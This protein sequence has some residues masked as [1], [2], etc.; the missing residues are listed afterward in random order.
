MAIPGREQFRQ[1]A[2]RYVELPGAR[3]L[4]ALRLTPNAVTLLGFA[5]CAVASFLVGS[6]WLLA[7]GI[8]FLAGS[9]LDLMD[10]ALARLTGTVRPFGA[11]AGLGIRP[12]WRSGDVPGTG[13]IRPEGRLQR[14]LPAVLH[15]GRVSGVD[16]LAGSELS[17]GP[18]RRV[19]S[20][21]PGRHHDQAGA[22]GPAGNRAHH[23]SN[24]LVRIGHRR[25]FLLHPF[26]ENVHHWSPT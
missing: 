23:G 7:G 5:V 13:N 15:H 1:A 3:L 11:L 8:V 18:G 17:S 26:S 16:F 12:A 19:G 14:G 25:R 2:L 9:G 24:R 20:V 21:H 4:H 6:G 22:G 10:G